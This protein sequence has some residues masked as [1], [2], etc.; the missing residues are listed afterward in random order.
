[1]VHVIMSPH[2]QV[3]GVLILFSH[4]GEKH[5]V[6]KARR[7]KEGANGTVVVFTCDREVSAI[8]FITGEAVSPPSHAEGNAGATDARRGHEESQP[9]LWN[10]GSW[11]PGR[12][13]RRSDATRRTVR[14]ARRSSCLVVPRT[15][16]LLF[17]TISEYEAS[18]HSQGG[19]PEARSL[20]SH[21]A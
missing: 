14:E 5:R 3:Y 15:T 19:W 17:D 8:G 13:W 7:C 1:M 2:Q 10:M 6:D 12:D 11:C 16:H 4:P 20:S 9:N 18:G 21:R